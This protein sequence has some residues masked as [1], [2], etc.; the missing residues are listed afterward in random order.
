ML[1]NKIEKK[2]YWNGRAPNRTLSGARGRHAV[3]LFIEGQSTGF[4]C[5]ETKIYAWI[6][7][8]DLVV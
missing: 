8:G 6:F 3:I 1:R 2:K 4:S 7:D 5:D